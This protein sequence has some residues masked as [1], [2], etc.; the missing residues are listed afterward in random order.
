MRAQ[1][2]YTIVEHM[3]AKAQALGMRPQMIGTSIKKL[4]EETGLHRDTIR[5]IFKDPKMGFV[6]RG[7]AWRIGKDYKWAELEK[8][9]KGLPNDVSKIIYWQG[10]PDFNYDE[11]GYHVIL[12]KEERQVLSKVRKVITGGANVED[13]N[14]VVGTAGNNDG[15][16]AEEKE[17]IEKFRA[18]SKLARENT[19]EMLESAKNNSH[20]W[21]KSTKKI[22]VENLRNDLDVMLDKDENEE[23]YITLLK[24]ALAVSVTKTKQIRG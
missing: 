12:T 13:I 18:S 11:A 21:E 3:T 16:S 15:L 4:S 5:G 14:I 7:S 20:D 10:M 24:W 23:K 19:L 17:L 6:E 1:S 2:V 9:W 8:V 22:T